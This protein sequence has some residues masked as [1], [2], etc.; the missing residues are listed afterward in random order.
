MQ[1]EGIFRSIQKS[2]TTVRNTHFNYT[3]EHWNNFKSYICGTESPFT[4]CSKCNNYKHTSYDVSQYSDRSR[5]TRIMCDCATFGFN[6]RTI[7][8][9]LDVASV[10]FELDAGFENDIY[11]SQCNNLKHSII[12]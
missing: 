12:F 9:E 8:C 3:N 7:N 2:F 11:D 4:I 1:I 6:N 10:E 5:A